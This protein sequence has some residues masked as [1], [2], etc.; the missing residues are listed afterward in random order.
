EVG[1]TRLL[2]AI[3]IVLTTG[4]LRFEEVKRFR[5]RRVIL[6]A[7]RAVKIHGDGELLGESPAE[8]EIL[9]RSI[10]VMVPQDPATEVSVQD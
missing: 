3:P 9:P 10:R 2:E 7:D 8:F 6:R 5:C 4:D 1:W